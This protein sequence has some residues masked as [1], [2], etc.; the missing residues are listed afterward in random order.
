MFESTKWILQEHNVADDTKFDM[1]FPTVVR[2]P[3]TGE[4]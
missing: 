4:I 2:P 3:M 1:L